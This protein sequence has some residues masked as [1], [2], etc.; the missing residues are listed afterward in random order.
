MISILR[1]LF[2]VWSDLQDSEHCFEKMS[3]II[4]MPKEQNRSKNKNGFQI[5]CF[6][7]CTCMHLGFVSSKSGMLKV[8]EIILG[9]CLETLL[10]NFG[11]R[12]LSGTAFQSCLTTISAC[13]SVS[14][15]LCLCYTLSAKSFYLIRQSMFVSFSQLFSQ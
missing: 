8:F 6:R 13:L 15:L 11:S 7:V 9:S 12:E 4:R 1:L 3:S 2:S 14:F 10:I 5:G